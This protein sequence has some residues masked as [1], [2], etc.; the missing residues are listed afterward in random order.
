MPYTATQQRNLRAC[1][2]CGILKL[3]QEFLNQGC[4]NCEEYLEY[5]G[6]ADAID[7]CTSQVWEGMLLLIDPAKSWVARFTRLNRYMPGS[8]AVKVDGSLPESVLEKLAKDGVQY[9]P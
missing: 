7:D 1:M 6:H 8:Y 5:R 9:Y 3:Q 2:L 4:P